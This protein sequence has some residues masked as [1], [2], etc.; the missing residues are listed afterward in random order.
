M[1]CTLK[2]D[3]P[4]KHFLFPISC[5]TFSFHC[6]YHFFYIYVC[7]CVCVCVCIYTHTYLHIYMFIYIYVCLLFI[8]CL[9]SQKYKLHKGWGLDSFHLFM[10]PKPLELCQANKCSI[11]ICWMRNDDCTIQCMVY[12]MFYI[13]NLKIGWIS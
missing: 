4:T 9:L 7:V 6:T 13:W 3:F 1:R 5:C 10:Y 11:N 2:L 12:L 8:I